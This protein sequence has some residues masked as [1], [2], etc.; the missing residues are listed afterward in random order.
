[1]WLFMSEQITLCYRGRSRHG[2]TMQSPPQSPLTKSWGRSWLR[3]AVYLRYQRL[4][5]CHLNLQLLAPLFSMEM[6]AFSLRGHPTPDF[7]W[8]LCLQTP[9]ISLCCTLAMVD[10]H[11]GSAPAVLVGDKGTMITPVGILWWHQIGKITCIYCS[12]CYVFLLQLL[13][14]RVWKKRP[15]FFS[16]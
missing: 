7:H 8:G 5:S 16:A 15:R 2:Q 6:D 13:L 10:P 1:M 4:A 12:V 14:H 9:V 11:F 3:G